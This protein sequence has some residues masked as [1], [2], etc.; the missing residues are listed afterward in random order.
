[1]KCSMK[2]LAPAVLLLFTTTGCFTTSTDTSRDEMPKA[3]LPGATQE[4]MFYE[5]AEAAAED[6]YAEIIEKAPE[7]NGCKAGVPDATSDKGEKNVAAP[8]SSPSKP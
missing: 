6:S 1:M 2:N 7:E 4:M 5:A 3:G 8:A